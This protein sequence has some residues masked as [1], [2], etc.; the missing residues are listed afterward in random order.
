MYENLGL[1]FTVSAAR[2]TVVQL[3]KVT[4]L[5]AWIELATNQGVY[6]I[7][8]SLYPILYID[9]LFVFLKCLGENPLV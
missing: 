1:S 7:A 3:K 6:S 9:W 2:P 5:L 4:P 8:F